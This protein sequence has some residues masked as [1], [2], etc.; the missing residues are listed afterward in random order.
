LEIQEKAAW[1][2][3]L[4]KFITLNINSFYRC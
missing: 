3:C 2:V 4:Q 1:C